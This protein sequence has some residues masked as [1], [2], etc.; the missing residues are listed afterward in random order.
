[1]E[2]S[3]PSP[4]TQDFVK[5]AK[6]EDRG[7][8]ALQ[9]ETEKSQ[10]QL[11]KLVRDTQGVLKRPAAGVVGGV[12]AAM[13]FSDLGHPDL[14]LPPTEKFPK[15]FKKKAPEAPP[16]QDWQDQVQRLYQLVWSNRS[17]HSGSGSQFCAF[18]WPCNYRFPPP[19]L[20]EVEK[21]DPEHLKVITN[22]NIA[23]SR[24]CTHQSHTRSYSLVL[25]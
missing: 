1:M 21:D 19:G 11:H 18:Q 24:G 13:G 10:R 3:E 6:W 22:Q 7:H 5:L 9:Q 25:V 23:K 14:E 12:S 16:Q 2:A 17:L 15:R 4:D 8:Y 20:I